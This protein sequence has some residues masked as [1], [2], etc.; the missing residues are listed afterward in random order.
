MPL[1]LPWIN[2][3][4]NNANNR[5]HKDNKTVIISLPHPVIRKDLNR[6]GMKY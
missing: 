2:G 5:I 6:M 4:H 3:L 1:R